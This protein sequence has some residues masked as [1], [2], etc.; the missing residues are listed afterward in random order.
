MVASFGAILRGVTQM[1]RQ[2][3]TRNAVLLTIVCA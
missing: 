1:Y 3:Y 2:P